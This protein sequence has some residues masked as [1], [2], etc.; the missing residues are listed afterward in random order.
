[1]REM[2]LLCFDSSKRLKELIFWLFNSEI[3]LISMIVVKVSSIFISEVSMIFVHFLNCVDFIIYVF[4]MTMT[5]SLFVELIS[6]KII[7][8]VLSKYK[9]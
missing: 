5:F 7:K 4:E 6:T 2:I 3:L 1:M 9:V 8:S